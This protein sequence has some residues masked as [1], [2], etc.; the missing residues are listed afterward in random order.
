M[1][2]SGRGE[3]SADLIPLFEHVEVDGSRLCVRAAAPLQQAFVRRAAGHD[4]D[5][6][7][8]IVV[9]LLLLFGGVG[10]GNRSSWGRGCSG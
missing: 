7:A 2:Q 3:S 1:K 4:G 5:P 10:Y 8:L 9:V 6:F